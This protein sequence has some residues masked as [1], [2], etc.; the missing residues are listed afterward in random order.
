MSHR[1]RP[2]RVGSSRSVCSVP[3]ALLRSTPL[4]FLVAASCSP[5]LE[6]VDRRIDATLRER[7][8]DLGEETVAPYRSGG[9]ATASP[10]SPQELEIRPPT[11]N[12]PPGELGYQI[13]DE[14]RDVS[15]RLK[16]FARDSLTN[17]DEL[18]GL[19]ETEVAADANALRLTLPLAFV[20]SQQTA[21]EYL[22]AEE[23]LIL[24]SIRL[25]IE[26]HLWTPRLFNDTFAGISGDGTDGR[27][28][29]ALDV[30]NT[31]RVNQ[32]LPF[33]GQVEARWIVRATE[34]LREQATGRYRQSADLVLDASIP[35]LRGAGSVAREDLIQAER[36]LVY[37]ARDFEEFR[38]AFLVSIAT[39]FYRLVETR[40]RI[41]NQGRQLRSLQD[42]EQ[43]EADRV[44][45]G[46]RAAF[47]RKIAENQVLSA[48]AAL[49]NLYEQYQ[50]QLDQFKIRLGVDVERPLVI[51]DS[52][53]ELPEPDVAL[54]EGVRLAL[55]YRLD[56]QTSRDLVA[57]AKRRVEFAK[58]DLLPDLDVV[59]TTTL[60]TNP[61]ARVQGLA[62]RAEDA[63]YSAGMNFSLPLDRRIERLNVRTAQID[64]ERRQREYEQA[65]DT[66][67]VRV[68]AALR[69]IDLARSSLV[70]AEQQV[71]INRGRLEEQRLKIA[72]VTPQDVVDSENELLRAENQR[73]QARTNLRLSVLNYLLESDQIRVAP[74]G[75]LIQLAQPAPETPADAG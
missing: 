18:A 26:R 40:E 19:D 48:R 58:N 61:R 32:R 50:F 38:R 33:G 68:R 73:D 28:E 30:I 56:L 45:A 9:S 39:D 5:S 35:L 29:H 11:R 31:L 70:L 74:D 51:L 65:R 21:R 36:D 49:E 8:G 59:A 69:S 46:R 17:L 63:T 55:E 43:A 67:I 41:K 75:T 66:A 44:A 71:E 15:A 27:F 62:P 22:R 1:L 13:A 14:A 7:I 4:L 12:P 37:A 54:D 24:T 64:L 2:F 23:D 20:T 60:P 34:Q 6:S 52:P 10:L 72:E 42:L 57:D 53:F 3:C 47:Q 16:Q 25:L